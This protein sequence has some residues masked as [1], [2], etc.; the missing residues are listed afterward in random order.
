M[1]LPTADMVRHCLL[2][3]LLFWSVTIFGQATLSGA[4]KMPPDKS[5]PIFQIDETFDR[6]DLYGYLYT[7]TTTDSTL[8]PRT[9]QTKSSTFQLIDRSI[10]D[11]GSDDRFHW[12]K[13]RL[14]N[15]S[16]SRMELVSYLH[17]NELTDVC[18]YVVDSRGS[19]RYQELH[20]NNHTLVIDKP[21]PSQFFAIP[22]TM[23]PQENLTLYW[24]VQRDDGHIVFPLRLYSKQ[25]HFLYNAGYNLL[26]SL[27]Y[28]VL[29]FT[30]LFAAILFF[31]TK[32]KILFYY[33][34]YCLF[35]LLLSLSNEGIF[36]QFFH[37]N[38]PFQDDNI[39]MIF[40][41]ILLY[42]ITVFSV[43]FLKIGTYLPRWFIILSRSLSYTS[44]A[45]A[46]LCAIFPTS[47]VMLV[48][49][50]MLI[51]GVLVDVFWMII[52][53][54]I[55]KKRVAFVYFAGVFLFFSN[56]IWL[57]LIALFNV[58]ATWFYYLTILYQTPVEF[59]ILGIELGYQL[60]NDRNRS[61]QRLNV[62]QR[63]FT[64]SILG[65][66]D[67]ERKRI[68]SDLHDDLGGTIATIRRQVSDIK[69]RVLQKE[70]IKD[71]DE[72]EPLIEKSGQDLRRI[73]HN[74]MPP[75]FVRIG[76]LYS[77]KQRV[78]TLPSKPI[79]F[80]FLTAGR[81]KRLDPEVELN[82]YR[83]VSELIQNILKHSQAKHATVQL[84]YFD[85]QL[86]ILV[87]DDG[88]GDATI[89]SDRQVPGT[90]IKNCILRADYIGASLTR[91]V[92]SAGTFVVLEI[93]YSSTTY[94]SPVSSQ[95]LNSR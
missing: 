55:K 77:L 87:E 75:E 67:S 65:A 49:L 83:I 24:R 35:Y 51:L 20:L 85:Q 27:S 19:V 80:E 54:M 28:G 95:D 38:L 16:S 56:S 59:I 61:L 81:E 3:Y 72:L 63:N 52:C 69:L 82:A 13:F 29:A 14:H 53:G 44:L 41:G 76:L 4:G 2:F 66:Q 37:F 33:A 12:I 10:P 18:F 26:A 73:S 5:I 64:A 94:E 43:D 15:K 90:G 22:F 11:F 47:S 71:F 36:K 70:I 9:L 50:N 93:P 79:S 34:G 62:L 84:L 21:I 42:F 68:A 45:F 91:E 40:S 6:H 1:Y 92:S 48:F 58:Q 30:F 57:A 86:R 46:F 74:L 60:I 78:A 31:V 89:K 23:H 88:V 25:S 8:G 17:S 32:H 39:R 7:F